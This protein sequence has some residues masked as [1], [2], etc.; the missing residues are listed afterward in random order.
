MTNGTVIVLGKTGV[1]FGAGMSGGFAIV[2]DE[3]DT[4]KYKYNPELVEI[5]KINDKENSY[6]ESFLK[7]SIVIM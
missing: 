1:N 3:D 6:C 5:L 7:D 2:L 4:F